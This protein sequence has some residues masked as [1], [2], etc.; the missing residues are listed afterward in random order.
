MQ[1]GTASFQPNHG[2]TW[3]SDVS[4]YV[5]GL[6][7]V[8]ATGERVAPSRA[9][10]V[11]L[12]SAWFPPA[13]AIGAIR[14]GHF[15]KSFHDAGHDVRV[16]TAQNPGDQS[17]PLGLPSNRVV[18]VQAPRGGEMLDRF[19]RPP[20]KLVRRLVGVPSKL[21]CNETA[22]FAQPPSGSGSGSAAR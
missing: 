21:T 6:D 5:S 17:L 2:S 12:V 16:L 14:V 3:N 11:L 9:L 19:V 20:L 10:K 4:P 1:I 13:N 8:A 22:P 15:A 7:R 18:Y